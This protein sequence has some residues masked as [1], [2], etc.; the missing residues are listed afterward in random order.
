VGEDGAPLTAGESGELAIRGA[1]VMA[2]Y[3]RQPEATAQVIKDGWFHTGDLARV[4]GEGFVSIV[5][6]KKALIICGG[7][8]IHPQ[9]IT[10]V[11]LTHSKVGQAVT[12]G[13]P[14]AIWGEVV[15]C[16]IVPRPDAAVTADEITSYC[17]DRISP[18]HQ[19][20]VVRIVSELP[21]NPAGKVLVDQLKATFL[22]EASVAAQ[23]GRDN[24][25]EAVLTIAARIFNVDKTALHLTSTQDDT[26]GWDSLNHLTL[27]MEAEKRFGVALSARDILSFRALAELVACIRARQGQGNRPAA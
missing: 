16:A 22:T 20:R 8:N 3:F 24:V 12:F 27:V 25:E 14:D 4:D 1:N 13:L 18:R 17:Q 11:L 10:D 9:S 7:M 5:G 26:A 21:K 2:G 6:R 19:P 23:D 15:A